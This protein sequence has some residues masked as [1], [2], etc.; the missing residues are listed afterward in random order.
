MFY[1][2]FV[3]LRFDCVCYLVWLT[4]FLSWF[5]IAFD[6][7]LFFVCFV[8]LFVCWFCW[9][10]LT[11]DWFWQF[12]LDLVFCLFADCDFVFYGLCG[13]IWICVFGCWFCCV[14]FDLFCCCCKLMFYVRWF[15]FTLTFG[16]VVCFDCLYCW[17][18]L[19]LGFILIG[20]CFVYC[21]KLR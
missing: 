17:L 20:C 21:F 14:V 11:L 7:C 10:V 9:T 3:V 6:W 18:N 5:G 16:L 13:F 1:W 2:W 8:C 15:E 4:G 19:Y 12:C